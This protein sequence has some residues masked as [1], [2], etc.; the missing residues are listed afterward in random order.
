MKN[1]LLVI[2][3]ITLWL[4]VAMLLEMDYRTNG[5]KFLSTLSPLQWFALILTIWTFTS[6]LGLLLLLKSK[7]LFSLRIQSITIF[8]DTWELASI[9]IPITHFFILIKLLFKYFNGLINRQEEK[10]QKE[11]EK[12]LRKNTIQDK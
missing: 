12:E 11:L 4:I 6:M 10:Y 1:I 5:N 9:V 2:Y 3:T 7:D 8:F